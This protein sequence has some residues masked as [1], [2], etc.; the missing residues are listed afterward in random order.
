MSAVTG[1][2]GNPAAGYWELGSV[3]LF[4]SAKLSGVNAGVESR[5]PELKRCAASEPHAEILRSAATKDL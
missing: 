1:N 2:T 3:R 5:S 4:T